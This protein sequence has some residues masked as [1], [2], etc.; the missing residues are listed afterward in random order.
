MMY[1]GMSLFLSAR[2][3][4]A[5]MAAAARASGKTVMTPGGQNYHE[6]RY[7]SMCAVKAQ[8]GGV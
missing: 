3:W 1:T 5:T 7:A 4:R 8:N 6:Y 2:A